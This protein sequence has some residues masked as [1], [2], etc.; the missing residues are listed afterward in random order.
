M[1]C[2]SCCDIRVTNECEVPVRISF[3]PC[4]RQRTDGSGSTDHRP[5][6]R[7]SIFL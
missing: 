5:C 3:R 1:S 6:D 2:K 4:D 7:R